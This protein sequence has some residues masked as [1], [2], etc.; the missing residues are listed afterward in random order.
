MTNAGK[1]L[2]GRIRWTVLAVLFGVTVI[3][4]ADRAILSLAA[5]LMTQDL[6]IDPLQLGIVFSAFGWSYVA[7]QLPGGWL[8]DRFGVRRVYLVAIVAW[9]LF[10]AAQGA[11][12]FLSGA[13]AITA[14][15]LFRLMV[16]FAEAPSFPGNARIVASWFPS[17]ERGRATAIFTSAQYCATIVFAPIM[18]WIIGVIGWPEV[19]LFM[20]VVGL[21]AA[22][23]WARTVHEPHRHPRIQPPE[24]ALIVD[25]GAL[26]EQAE[27]AGRP[28]GATAQQIRALILAPS[29]WGLY[30]HQF[31]VNALTYFFITWFP[32]YLV[33]ER[34]LSIIETG[35]MTVIPSVCGFLGG[36]LGGVW[37]D[38]LLKRGHSLTM[39]RKLPIVTGMLMS[40]AI[41]GCNY[42]DTQTMVMIFM[43]LAFFGKGFGALGWAVMSDI[44]PPG[45]AGLSG[46][47]F[48]MFGNMSSIVTPI[49]IGFILQQTQSFELVLIFLAGCGFTAAFSLL[50]LFGKIER[51]KAPVPAGA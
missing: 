20:G 48:N 40:L 22:F 51:M 15:F 2:V 9:S 43:S 23:S 4:Y 1:P 6:G 7:A 38:W 17:S 46:G 27:P 39:A 44:A 16:G 42:S 24:L 19:F 5:P 3:N 37:S 41:L 28:D 30:L 35:L 36:L 12:V 49:A 45:A 13:A 34:D 21:I 32:V 10:T 25:G 50:F 29:L 47:I 14:L 8:L 26:I 18:A 11:V 31:C 33:Q